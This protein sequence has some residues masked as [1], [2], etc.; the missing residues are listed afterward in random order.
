MTNYGM[1]IK[2][3]RS[4]NGTEFKNTGLDDYLDSVIN[5]SWM[6]MHDK[7]ATYCDKHVSSRKCNFFVV[8]ILFH[9]SAISMAHA[10]VLRED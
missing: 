6:Y 2:H 5:L 4:D 7:N 9:L 10:H 3:I 1:K 8:T